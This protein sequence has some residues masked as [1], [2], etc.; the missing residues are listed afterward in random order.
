MAKQKSHRQVAT[1]HYLKAKQA[2]NYQITK[3]HCTHLFTLLICYACY[4]CFYQKRCKKKGEAARSKTITQHIARDY[5][6]SKL[7]VIVS[8]TNLQ[9]FKTIV[10]QSLV[11]H[12]CN[13]NTSGDFP[14]DRKVMT[15]STTWDNTKIQKLIN[16]VTQKINS[17]YLHQSVSDSLLFLQGKEGLIQ[18]QHQKFQT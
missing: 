11:I 14:R 8:K 18:E 1:N 12:L 17:Q 2:G 16:T 13:H 4:T 3:Q 10:K 5:C 6:F 7:E 9:V 15:I